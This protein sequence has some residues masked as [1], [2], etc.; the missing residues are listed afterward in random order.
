A[1]ATTSAYGADLIAPLPE[2][3]EYVRVCDAFGDGFFFIP[4]TETCLRIAGRVRADYNIIVDFND[5]FEPLPDFGLAGGDNF[6]RFRSRAYLY[7]DSRTSTEFGLL[8]TFSEVYFT[9]EFGFGNGDQ[10]LATTGRASAFTTLNRAFVQF[11]G[12]T[13]G[14]TQSFYDF[15]DATYGTA[16]FLNTNYSDTTTNVAAYTFAFGN[17][18]SASVSAEDVVERSVGMANPNGVGNPF[19]INPTSPLVV[20]YGGTRA[21]DIVGN[22]RVD[23]AWGSAQIMGAGHYLS[24]GFSN[25]DDAYG[26][27]AGG[28]V[29]VNVPFGA[30]TQVGIQG[31]YT[32]GALSY[33]A[34]TPIGP[35]VA[36]A[37]V[38]NNATLK[39]VEAFSISGGGTFSIT[40]SI[41]AGVQGG[42]LWVDNEQPAGSGN[43][44]FRNY[45]IEG[46]VGYAPVPG[47]TLGAGAQ[48][49]YIDTDAAGDGSVLSTFLRAQRT[50]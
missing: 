9:S 45:D 30:S 26:F 22:L 41:A 47:F 15:L 19:A 49:K 46:F 42:F 4:G 20:G 39:L 10:V 43:T 17:G 25:V 48:F 8:R 21:P 35:L 1:V 28:G 18:F 6:T 36:D 14:R 3:V 29:T 7:L 34:E 5:G 37:V 13:F 2:P 24:S 23:Q 40:P 44:D 16:Q 31:S 11:G 33:V 50:F 12:L 38:G 27:A 32:Q